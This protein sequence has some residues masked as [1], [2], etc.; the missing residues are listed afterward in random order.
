MGSHQLNSLI[1]MANQIADNNSHVGGSDD[2]ANL[3]ANHIQKFWS[4][5]MK[6]EIIRYQKSNGDA[7][8]STAQK[9]IEK[10]TFATAN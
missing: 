9:A 2:I 7:L 8:N 10:L 3:V 6:E 1:K 4:R 5:T